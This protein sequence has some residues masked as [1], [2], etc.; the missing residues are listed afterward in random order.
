MAGEIRLPHPSSSTGLTL[1]ALLWDSTSQ[2]CTTSSGAFGA[3]ATGSLANYDIALTEKGTGS[4]FYAG[5]VPSNVAAGVYLATIYEQAGGSPAEGD[6]L[7]GTQ[8]IEWSGTAV[9]SLYSRLAPTTAGRTLDVSL[10]GEAGV[11]WA[12]VGTPGSTV[13]LSAT[14]VG[15]VSS[16]AAG[17]ITASS[18]ADGTIDRATFAA[19]TGLQ[20]IRSNTVQS[21]SSTTATLDASASG[22]NDYYK[23]CVIYLVA[24]TG[25]GQARI[26][27]AYNGTTKV[28]T[29]HPAWATNPAVGTTYAVMPFGPADLAA[30]VGTT[31]TGRDI[32][33]SVLLSSGTGTGQLD[34][35]SGVV[36]SNLAQILGTA[37][38]ETAGLLAAGFKK[39][40]NVSTPTGTVNSLPDAVPGATNGLFIAGTN[41]PITI[42]GSGD[43]VT[44]SSTGGG[45]HGL[46][47]SGHTTGDG[48]HLLGG[49]TGTGLELQGGS[50][51][52]MGLHCW[53]PGLSHGAQFLGGYDYDGINATG[54]NTG[55]GMSLVSGGAGG[56][57][58]S[59][60]G[61][62]TDID[63]ADNTIDDAALAA[64]AALS[65]PTA[66]QNAAALMDLS[67]GVETGL[68][69]RQALRLMVAALA[70]EL[71]GAA[72]TTITIRNA[73]ADD[74][75]RIIATVDSSGNRSSLT[76]DLT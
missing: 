17:G 42:T 59:A 7:I 64:I 51:S 9:I 72:T 21:G 49:A 26:C 39:F 20:T 68:T 54:T 53:A 71:S 32:G 1:Y 37:L 35:T 29:V 4:S 27:T 62:T 31:Q 63:A 38:T 23:G 14:T 40:F 52:G 55:D 19:D 12:N 2:V 69:P 58:L 30:I 5:N 24:N 6:Y 65:I 66:A 48:A 45:G 73:V 41:A 15:T 16:V 18:V 67:N 74:K 61:T 43:A 36:K 56:A 46:Y 33:A 25:V 8:T 13:A 11:D 57:G 76:L 3:Y 10:G 44:I 70:G 28:A 47:I 75:D 50:T 34:F 22:T 60:S